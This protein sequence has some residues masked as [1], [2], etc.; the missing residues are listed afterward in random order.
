MSNQTNQPRVEAL[1]AGAEAAACK[2]LSAAVQSTHPSDQAPGGVAHAV[3]Q[4]G[5]Q[6]AVLSGLI[7]RFGP[8]AA[9]AALGFIS[10]R[11]G[12]Q[13]RSFLDQHSS[14]VEAVVG[15]DQWATIQTVLS[16]F[17]P[18]NVAA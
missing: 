5:I 1:V 9:R 6:S 7:A 8:L 14:Q 10:E 18:D 17:L 13:I 2:R 15:P 12:E 3:R 11:Y 4:S 16:V